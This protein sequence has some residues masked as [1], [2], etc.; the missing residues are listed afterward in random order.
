MKRTGVLLASLCICATALQAAEPVQRI[1][2]QADAEDFL[3]VKKL[4]P[5]DSRVVRGFLGTPV[6]GSLESWDYRGAVRE[7]PR[8]ASD[9]VH[10]AFNGNDGLHIALD[11]AAG[12][13]VVVL[14][15]G[16]STRLYADVEGLVKPENRAPL[17]EFA[18][19]KFAQVCFEQ[20]VKARR[21]SFFDSR[22]GNIAD[23]AF[24][25]TTRGAFDTSGAEAFA[26]AAGAEGAPREVA[27]PAPESPFS[28][29]SVR[30]ALEKK[31]APGDRQ[32]VLI[33]PGEGAPLPVRNYRTIHLM[34]EPFD[35]ERGLAAV[36]LEA[37]ITERDGP[38]S[39]TA[40]VHD[41]LNPRLDLA[42]VQFAIDRPGVIRLAFDIPDQLLLKGSRVW[43]ALE[44]DRNVRLTGPDGRGS[45]R[46]WLQFV[47]RERALPEA[48]AWRKFLMRSY[49]MLLSEPRPWGGYGKQSREAYF[50]SGPYAAQC[51]EFFMTLDQCLA[52]APGDDLVRQY[53]EWVYLRHL[54]ALSEVVVPPPPDG[55][56]A[57]AHYAREAWLAARGTAQWWLDHRLVP[58]GEFGGRLGDDSDLYQNF[59]DLPYFESDGV[60]A[61]LKEAGARMAELAQEQNLRG[62]LNVHATDALHAYEEG[63]NHL[64]LMARW[65]YGDPTFLE[66][67]MESARNMAA[68]TIKTNDGRR[69]FR[70]RESMGAR[71]M[72]K[73]R[74]PAIDGHATPL[75]WHT[76]LQYAD[77]NRSPEA[78]RVVREWADT[79][80]R[81]QRP[82]QWATA[83]EV[84]SGK[85]VDAERDRPLYGGYR[86]Q[87]A[88][89]VWL[90]AL[91]GDARYLGPL[92]HFYARGQ[93]PLPANVYL[94]DVYALGGLDEFDAKALKPLLRDS[95]AA[96]LLAADDPAPL[97]EATIGRGERYSA[98]VACLADARRWP[99]MQTTAEP[100][101]DRVFLDIIEHASQAY[102]GGFCKRNKFNP[103]LAASWEGFGTDYAALVL[104]NRRDGLKA[105]VYNFRGAPMTG[106]M[107]VW[108]LDHGRY[109]V[110]IG[111]DANSDFRID[112]GAA[113][114]AGKGTVVQYTAEL[115]RAEAIAVTL[116]PRAVTII[117]VKQT[118]RLDPL[119]TR[120]DLA[121]AARELE[122][123]SDSIRVVVHN[124]GS[125]D[126][127]EVVVAVLDAQGK[128]VARRSV[129]A[130]AAPKDLAPKQAAF[131]FALPRAAE[132]GW[133][134]VVD[135]DRRV[136]EIFEG[137]NE[138]ALEAMPP[139][140][141]RK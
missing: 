138:I 100:Y 101:T 4:L 84:L 79:W 105:A 130:L 102:L 42:A 33:A 38:C 81:Y 41:P 80:L 58:T 128:E 129:G 111:P 39:L 97:V 2:V 7:Y 127:G 112:G 133:R 20:P 107:R 17:H 26:V 62:G 117:E 132:S 115:A 96:A 135:P 108:A 68:L 6:D 35:R 114:G 98:T 104:E 110:T 72:D 123:T 13:N 23:V 59:A 52:L 11:D 46:I 22:D 40:H 21:V 3:I 9:G 47:P 77:Y 54:D 109:G 78:L 55:V 31:H 124:L 125:A 82:G 106:R 85:V 63:I 73:P 69:H 16:A 121:L 136:P 50:A 14:R 53:R 1:A 37:K 137:N 51:P 27:L 43:L 134:L 36:A 86:T 103:T 60:G 30:A 45:P 75:M 8:T 89:F 28:S 116:A 113:T 122:R 87:A 139:I 118:G 141:E 90:Y 67:G 93:T 66:R 24:Y 18:G 94:A 56:P 70:D 95:P 12:F 10:Y 64:A 119:H 88:V 91:T 57:W 19:A 71:D 5:A 34:T 61:R 48:L 44:F 29:E 92:R 99:D 74:P 83:V 120:A 32:T 140:A 65:F 126:A 25:R 49:F 131:A 15:G 76:T